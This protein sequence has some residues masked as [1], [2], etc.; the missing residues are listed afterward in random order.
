MKREIVY[1]SH[2]KFRLKIRNIPSS[3]PKRVFK[4]AKEHYYDT[5][6]QH[7]IAV[8]KLKYREKIREFA[9]VYDKKEGIIEIVTIHPLKAYQKLSRINSG[10][11]QR[12]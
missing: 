3:L 12:I 4:E 1:T 11:W 8:S 5:L 10:R 2:L 7:Y 9:L 6:T